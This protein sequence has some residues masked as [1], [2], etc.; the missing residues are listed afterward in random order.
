[1]NNFTKDFLLNTNYMVFI[2]KMIPDQK[3]REFTCKKESKWKFFVKWTHIKIKGN[4]HMSVF[5]FLRTECEGFVPNLSTLIWS[6]IWQKFVDLSF[7]TFWSLCTWPLLFFF[8]FTCPLQLFCN[9]TWPSL[10]FL[11]FKNFTIL[12]FFDDIEKA[13]PPLIIIFFALGFVC[14][15]WHMKC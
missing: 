4:S 2:C 8:D 5:N 1:M 11:L 7:H 10:F 9:F 6:K 12:C 14:N 15:S 13:P 3:K